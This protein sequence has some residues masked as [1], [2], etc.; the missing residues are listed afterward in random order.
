M[1]TFEVDEKLYQITS[2]TLNR[3]SI[4]AGI[5]LDRLESICTAER[6][7]RLVVLPCEVGGTVYT[8]WTELITPQTNHPARRD[9]IPAKITSIEIKEN[10]MFICVDYCGMMYHIN[11]LGK[12]VFITREAAEAAKERSE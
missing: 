9:I 6:E 5:P 10:G 12:T 11:A 3:A 8:I 4:T 2:E 1:K 7:N